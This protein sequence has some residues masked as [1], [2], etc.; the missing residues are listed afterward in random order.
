MNKKLEKEVTKAKKLINKVERKEKKKL[1]KHHMYEDA[2]CYKCSSSGTYLE[3]KVGYGDAYNIYY[4]RL[5]CDC[6]YIKTKSY[7]KALNNKDISVREYNKKL[8]KF[9]DNNSH[10]K[11]D[12][13]DTDRSW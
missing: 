4:D 2:S 7:K 10:C 9:Y 13:V 12:F 3:E 11:N 6:T 1:K 8:K 5:R